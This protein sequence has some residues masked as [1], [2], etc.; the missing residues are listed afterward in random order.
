MA[1]TL[2]A[3]EKKAAVEAFYTICAR[4]EKMITKHRPITA[5]D[6]ARIAMDADAEIYVE[7]GY[8]MR[9]ILK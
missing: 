2:S 4:L 1:H 7:Y 9:D 5:V 3:D 6:Q 8:Y